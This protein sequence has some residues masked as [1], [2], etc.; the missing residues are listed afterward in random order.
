MSFTGKEINDNEA[1]KQNN[2]SDED[3]ELLKTLNTLNISSHKENNKNIGS[4]I[5]E[6]DNK[7]NDNNENKIEEENIIKKIIKKI[8]F[9]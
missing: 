9:I 6:N 4:S 8:I 2:L 1:I 7:N 5:K 3:E